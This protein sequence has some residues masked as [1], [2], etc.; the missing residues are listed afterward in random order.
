MGS[1]KIGVVGCGKISDQYLS[2]A[3]KF[4]ILDV[5]AVSDLDL[6]V[7][8]RQA[9]K[10]GVPR[11]VSMDAL[12]ADATIE[13]TL[14]LTIP[15]A[16]AGVAIRSLEAGKHTFAEKPLG[17]S[18]DEGVRVL[19]AMRRTGKRVGC[20]PDTFLGSAVQTARN[21]IDGGAIGR[22]VACTAFLMGRGHEHWHP[23]PAFYYAPG[24]GPMFDMGPYYLT[25][26]LQLLGPMRRVSGMASIAIPDR[27]ITSDSPL[28][29]TPI[30]VTTPDHVCGT[31]EFANGCVGTIVTSFATRAAQYD[32]AHPIQVFGERGSILVPDPNQ[33]DG[34]VRLCRF[35]ERDAFVDA[36]VTGTTGYGRAV[37]LAEMCDAIRAGRPHRASAEQAFAVLDAMQGF[38]EASDGG[39]AVD[40][41]PGYERPA[42]LDGS[43][44]F[45]AFD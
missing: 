18:R 26:L 7:A 31:I 43:K 24:G 35:G 41:E 27:T 39:R 6:D 14:N 36:P 23:S 25:A 15:A 1:V 4:P 37:G 45:G 29:G 11:A 9:A 2:T 16:H 28:K 40:L 10:H 30:D 22:P 5:V 33:F 20:A 44:G 32:V 42:A 12:L 21:L 13:L 38:L 3:K 34:V 19:D 8:R 17:I